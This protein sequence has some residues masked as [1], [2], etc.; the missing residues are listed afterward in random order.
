MTS[1]QFIEGKF[2]SN[3]IYVICAIMVSYFILFW[4]PKRFTKL[5]TLLLILYGIMYATIMDTSIGAFTFDYYD[6]LDG[7]HFTVMT[8]ILYLLYG[9]FGYFFIYFYEK[10]NIRGH[11]TIIYLLIW[12]TFSLGVDWV[13]VQVGVFTYKNGYHALYSFPIF[14]YVQTLLLLFYH[15]VIKEKKQ[16]SHAS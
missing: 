12:T 1:I 8:G 9:P 3:D 2:D 5:E 16:N 14:L 4:L 10:L 7:E 6:I 15:Y 13:N 11:Y